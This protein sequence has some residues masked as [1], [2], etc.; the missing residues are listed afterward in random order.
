[1]SFF[2]IVAEVSF[3]SLM[4]LTHQV[5]VYLILI[6]VTTDMSWWQS[7]QTLMDSRSTTDVPNMILQIY[8]ILI[9][10]TPDMSW[11]QSEHTLDARNTTDVQNVS[12][13]DVSLFISV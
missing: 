12:D 8:S 4:L 6:S 7:W 9:S 13:S 3:F 2:F 5:E 1:M 10:V 11:W